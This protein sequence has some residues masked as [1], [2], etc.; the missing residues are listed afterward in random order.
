MKKIL[1]TTSALTLLAGAAAAD[2]SFSGTGRIGVTNV[3]GPATVTHR[4]RVNVNAS[5]ETDGGLKV[6][7]YVRINMNG[8]ALGAIGAPR[9]WIGNGMATLTVGNA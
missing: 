9:L 8:G 3:T 4:F 7:G 2:I 6:G 5:G 1:L